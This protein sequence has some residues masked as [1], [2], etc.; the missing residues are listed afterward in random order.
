MRKCYFSGQR[1]RD[2]TPHF[3]PL[4]L[5]TSSRMWPT[6]QTPGKW[7]MSPKCHQ[8]TGEPTTQG[9]TLNM[10]LVEYMT[11]GGETCNSRMGYHW[12]KKKM[13]RSPT[14]PCRVWDVLGVFLQG[15]AKQC[16][17]LCSNIHRENG[18]EKLELC[19]SVSRRYST[20]SGDSVQEE[21]II[22]RTIRYVGQTTYHNPP[23]IILAVHLPAIVFKE[24]DGL[25]Y[26]C[27]LSSGP[28]SSKILE[29]NLN[30]SEI[31]HQNF[32]N[33]ELTAAL[34]RHGICYPLE[35]PPFITVDSK[36]PSSTTIGQ[37]RSKG[38]LPVPGGT[39]A[40]HC[41]YQLGRTGHCRPCPHHLAR[42]MSSQRNQVG[43]RW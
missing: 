3:I 41:G 28:E 12:I 16:I 7:D 34:V 30:I 20:P 19:L 27:W 14:M 18:V 15:S 36:P 9:I 38:H 26:T 21:P 6:K 13:R 17:P 22:S 37:L 33:G 39:L 42:S 24:H 32:Q 40:S 29:T 31:T 5:D 43:V 23:G 4:Q 2:F 25:S 35:V 1:H 11:P 8:T 10:F